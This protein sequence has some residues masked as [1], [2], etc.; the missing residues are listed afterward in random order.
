[1]LLSL[2]FV[3]VLL[4]LG[5]QSTAFMCSL[6]WSQATFALASWCAEHIQDAQQ[7]KGTSN[8][9]CKVVPERM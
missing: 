1:M 3:V 2:W 4:W 5:F 7:H 9:V 6:S 8:N